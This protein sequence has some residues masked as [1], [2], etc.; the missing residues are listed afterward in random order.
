MHLRQIWCRSWS[1]S[2]CLRSIVIVPRLGNTDSNTGF[3]TEH[4]STLK[5]VILRT[6]AQTT[7]FGPK[8]DP[9]DSKAVDIWTVTAEN[10]VTSCHS[11]YTSCHRISSVYMPQH[12]MATGAWQ[13][14]GIHFCTC[15]YQHH[16]RRFL[17]SSM[18]QRPTHSSIHES[19]WEAEGYQHQ[20]VDRT[21]NL[22]WLHKLVST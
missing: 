1:H 12:G 6:F 11:N 7:G 13:F 9:D 19:I 21:M 22:A 5:T 20:V 8:F 18:S 3:P 17:Y 16:E 10:S 15:V 4:R 2:L 14:Y